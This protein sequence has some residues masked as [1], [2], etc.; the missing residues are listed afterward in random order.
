MKKIFTILLIVLLT[1][2]L[3]ACNANNKPTKNNIE[4]EQDNII[5]E[6]K[7]NT[8][9]EKSQ[10]QVE[11]SS[12][13]AD[14]EKKEVILYFVNNEYINTGDENLEKLIPEKRI[15]KY[16]DIS[17]EETIVQELIKGPKDD[18]LSTL[19]P[20]NVKILGVEVSDN[21]AFVNFSQE[22]L[23]GSSMEETFTINQIV[24]SL[25]ELDNIKR[26]QFLIDGEKAESLMGH[27]DITEPFESLQ[28]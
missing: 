11:E 28:Y 27:F 14:Y 7:E 5:D 21:T 4:K 2:S 16:G 6:R 10:I 15:V 19:I 8:T 13:K 9:E 25:L 23:Y 17:L 20:A 26:V 22:D 12:P 3:V 1:V 24:G 18:N